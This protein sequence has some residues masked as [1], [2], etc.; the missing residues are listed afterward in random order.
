MRFASPVSLA[1][2]RDSLS[3]LV[4]D[5]GSQSTRLVDV[6]SRQVSTL[7]TASAFARENESVELNS[8]IF[9]PL[10]YPP[11]TEA[12]VVTSKRVDRLGLVVSMSSPFF[13]LFFYLTLLLSVFRQL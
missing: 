7:L 9:D 6:A 1:I 5:Y 12:F 8:V 3:L 4:A 2:R 11:Q 10:C 13:S